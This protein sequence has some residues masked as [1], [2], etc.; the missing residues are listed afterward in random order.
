MVLQEMRS[1]LAGDFSLSKRF[2]FAS[3]YVPAVE[4][5]AFAAID[6]ANMLEA[7]KQLAFV[8]DLVCFTAREV[9]LLDQ[10]SD[11]VLHTMPLRD[12]V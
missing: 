3:V 1:K 6:P 10:S 2:F 4:L 11:E 5:G 8:G 7:D 12:K 9:M